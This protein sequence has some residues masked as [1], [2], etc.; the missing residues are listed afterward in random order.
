MT[1]VESNEAPVSATQAADQVAT[2][3]AIQAVETVT[4]DLK[5]EPAQLESAD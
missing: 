4:T 3:A 5:E 2:Q 1:V